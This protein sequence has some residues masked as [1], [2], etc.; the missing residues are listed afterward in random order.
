MFLRYYV[1][2]PAAAEAIETALV[3]QPAAWLP[4]IA[5][6]ARRHGDRLLAEA[7]FRTPVGVGAMTRSVIVTVG[8]AVRFPSKL[9]MPISWEP[10]G[11]Q[12]PGVGRMLPDLDAD[13]EVGP[14]G[15]ARTQL[16]IN[17]TYTPP[18]GTVGRTADRLL[19][20]RLAEATVKRFLDQ[21]GG[22]LLELAAD[23]GRDRDGRP[24]AQP[25]GGA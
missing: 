9:A 16:A 18:L 14:L 25:T 11:T 2:L 20:H 4:G 13:L 12:V 24:A 6:D 8:P 19:L 5:E 15:P 22:R 3:G 17:A 10:A 21:V 7:G 1:E 23:R